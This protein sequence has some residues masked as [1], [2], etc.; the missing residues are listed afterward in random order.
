MAGFLAP[1]LTMLA[2]AV[3]SPAAPPPAGTSSGPLASAGPS[4]PSASSPGPQN[5][6][7]VGTPTPS[8]G[9]KISNVLGN[10]LVQGGLDAY[11]GMLATPKREGLGAGLANAGASG[12]SGFETARQNQLKQPLMHAQL[13]LAQTQ[14]AAA[15]EK[16]DT[17][18]SLTPQQRTQEFAPKA[19]TAANKDT[20][21]KQFEAMAVSAS[22]QDQPKWISVATLVR[23]GVDPQKA[24]AAVFNDPALA[25]QKI[26]AGIKREGAQTT[27]ALAQANR[28]TAETGPDVQKSL[29]EANRA[30]IEAGHVGVATPTYQNWYVPTTKQWISATTKPSADAI[31]EGVITGAKTAQELAQ[32]QAAYQRAYNQF[33]NQYIKTNTSRI[34]GPPDAASVDAYATQHA[35]AE[36]NATYPTAGAPGM[37]GADTPADDAEVLKRIVAAGMTPA[38]GTD[39]SKGYFTPDGAFHEG[40]P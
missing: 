16:Q 27:E 13:G 8:W 1:L 25:N 2:N 35:T 11:F 39:G 30:N 3:K 22:P 12:L 24:I 31:P 29:A 28:A 4:M 34:W 20:I 38:L 15:K 5:P 40:A 33:A 23:A 21:A 37:A 17:L 9:D 7:G 32:R 6:M 26:E 10:P 14:A 19:A 36:M 18:A